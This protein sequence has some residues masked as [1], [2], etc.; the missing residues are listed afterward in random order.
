MVINRSLNGAMVN[1][2]IILLNSSEMHMSPEEPVRAGVEEMRNAGVDR[3]MVP[4]F[5]FAGEGGMDR[6]SEFGEK[7]IPL[8]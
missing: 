6:L 7:I 2:T 3:I 4:A 5:F 8:A 1:T